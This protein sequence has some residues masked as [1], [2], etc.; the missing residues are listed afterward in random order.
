MNQLIMSEEDA[1]INCKNFREK[2]ALAETLSRICLVSSPKS[3]RKNVRISAQQKFGFFDEKS[4]VFVPPKQLLMFLARYLIFIKF[5][6]FH[7]RDTIFKL[8]QH[9]LAPNKL[10]CAFEI[11]IYISFHFLN[12]SC[13]TFYWIY[14][15]NTQ[16]KEKH[17]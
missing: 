8:D 7:L 10:N 12:M 15:K 16:Y 5:P 11:K 17:N 4:G 9:L 14:P 1:E 13:I 2:F 3:Q 6:L